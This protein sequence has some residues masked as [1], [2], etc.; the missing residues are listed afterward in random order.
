MAGNEGLSAGVAAHGW[1]TAVPPRNGAWR[2]LSRLDGWVNSVYGSRWNPLYQSGAMTVALLAV[3]LVTGL[4]L[5]LFYRLGAPWES[6]ARM[7]DQAWTGRWIRGLHR[8]ASDGLVVTAAVHAFRMYAQRRTWGPRTLAWVSGLVLVGV[9]F[10]CGWT[11][12]VMVWDVQA[13]V[14]AVEGARFL[15]VLPIFSEPISRAFVGEYPLPSA[16]FFLNLF[17]HV[18]LPVGL[19][20]LVWV[21]VSRLAR[22]VLLP[23]RPLMWAVIGGFTALSVL[24]P[25]GMAPAADV[26]RVPATVPLDVFYGFWLPVTRVAPAWLVW[27]VGVSVAGLLVLVPVWTRPRAASR[28]AASR[29]NERLCTGCYQC[30]LDCPYDAI[31]MVPRAAGRTGMVARVDAAVCVSCGI[32]AGSCAPMGVGPGGR[33]G[34][35]QLTAVRPFRPLTARPSPA[36][37]SSVA[38]GARPRRSSPGRVS[39]RSRSS[40]PAT[41]TH[42]PSRR[43]SGTA[44]PESSLWRVRNATAGTGKAACGLGSVSIPGG[45]PT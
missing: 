25:V 8:Y 15:D 9:I 41:S 38:A 3:V 43:C 30:A 18:A 40:V 35:D 17:A 12:Y 37:S 26:L 28:P 27:A 13:Q 19:G 39:G 11:G 10:V 7:T 22:P 4:Y 42:R 1:G 36:W 16:F 31:A 21:H 23:P 24:W 29:V 14:L 34:R 6:V 32:C 33:T 2:L 45:R 5:L 44:P 20:L